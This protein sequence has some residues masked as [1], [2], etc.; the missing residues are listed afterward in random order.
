[1]CETCLTGKEKLLAWGKLVYILYMPRLQKNNF[2]SKYTCVS[3]LVLGKGECLSHVNI[4][5]NKIS[6]LLLYV[7]VYF[8]LVWE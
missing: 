7:R 5:R 6:A 3:S 1:M 2:Y 8:E 4:S